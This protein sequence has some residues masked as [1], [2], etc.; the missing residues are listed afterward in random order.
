MQTDSAIGAV[1]S[2]V[3]PLLQHVYLGNTLRNWIVAAVTFAVTLLV[4]LVVRWLVVRRLEP[5]SERTETK[6]DEYIVSLLK[7]TR[8]IFLVMLAVGPAL[9]LLELP[10]RISSL[11]IPLLRLVVII[12]VGLWAAELI[13]LHLH[14]LTK[15]RAATD[16]ASVTTIRAGALVIQLVLWIIIFLVVLRNFGVDVTALLTTLGIAGIAAALAVQNILS[17]LLASLSIVLDK[18]FVVGDF[19]VLDT[20]SGTVEEIGLKTTR[21]RSISGERLIFSNGDLLKS[22]IRNY[23][24]MKRRRIVFSFGLD[25]GAPRE[26]LE[27]VPEA[28]RDII[29]SVEHASFDRSHFLKFGD[30]A[31][32][33]ET[34]YYVTDK[35][36]TIY[37]NAQQ[38]INLKLYDR[39]TELG[40]SFA[41]PVRR[42]VMDSSLTEELEGRTVSDDKQ[43]PGL[44]TSIQPVGGVS[45]GGAK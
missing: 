17:D 11:V 3:T 32:E 40:A 4:L 15:R 38:Q 22:R 28:V 19:I 33:F 42:L 35:D 45:D 44:D 30:S 18:P 12:Q 5:L 10:E 31:L 21:L 1:R 29:E 36:Y 25:F 34:V 9:K 23:R 24:D 20:Y 37:M 7:N 27:K 8:H 2:T 43:P 39:I 14:T 13:T 26:V 16:V 6:I 41:Y